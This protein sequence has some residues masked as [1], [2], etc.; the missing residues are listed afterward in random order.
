MKQNI[1]CIDFDISSI[2]IFGLNCCKTFEKSNNI[3]EKLPIF[4]NYNQKKKIWKNLEFSKNSF[5]SRGILLRYFDISMWRLFLFFVL[6]FEVNKSIQKNFVKFHFIPSNYFWNNIYLLCI[7]LL[8]FYWL[9]F[10]INNSSI[11][12]LVG[13][14]L[15]NTMK[16]ILF[17]WQNKY[18]SICKLQTKFQFFFKRWVLILIIALREN[19]LNQYFYSK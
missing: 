4:G 18:S 8:Y 10:L 15:I 6:I 16:Y 12:K 5:F 11:E 3:I 17:F 9:D 14:L 2:S 7:W 13:F 1:I 19:M